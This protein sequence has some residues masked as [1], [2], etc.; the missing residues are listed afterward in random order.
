MNVL[1]TCAGR[2]NDLVGFFRD[3]LGTRG[4]VIA[5]D[6]NSSAPALMEAD[7]AIITPAVD[8]PGYFDAIESICREKTIRLLLS[9]N[10]LELGGLAEHAPRFRAF[11]TI[12]VISSPEAVACCLDKLATGHW[13]Q[14]CGIAAPETYCSVAE[15][16]AALAR[17][18][19]QYPLLIKPRWGTAS[20]GVEIVESHRELELAYEWGKLQ[21][22]RT[23]LAR[24]SQS[25]PELCLLI[26]ERLQGEEYGLDVVN[27]LSGRHVATLMRRKLAMRAG[28]TDRAVTVYDPNLVRIGTILGQQLAHIGSVDCDVMVTEKGC[29]VLDVNPRLGGG[30]PFSHLAGA[31]LPAAFI[32]WANGKEPDPVWL[33]PRSGIMSAKCDGVIVIDRTSPGGSV[34]PPTLPQTSE[35]VMASSR[36]A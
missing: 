18:A 33:R 32:A 7:Q 14:K 6:S 27:D 15:A 29:F 13:L 21:V 28:S 19:L 11:G 10:D 5:C 35:Q 1:L 24:L 31:N 34:H 2:R 8:R 12:P 9:V 26:Q 30:Y 22:R 17:G 36:G 16:R 25:D 20:M 4:Q 23:I 3:A